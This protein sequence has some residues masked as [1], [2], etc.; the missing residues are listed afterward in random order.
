MGSTLSRS[1]HL[2]DHV[3]NNAH[4]LHSMLRVV[5]VAIQTVC[6]CT[7]EQPHT[8]TVYI[9]HNSWN[10]YGIH[11]LK[12]QARSEI[13]LKMKCFSF[14]KRKHSIQKTNFFRMARRFSLNFEWKV[15]ALPFL[16]VI[17][18]FISDLGNTYWHAC[19]RINLSWIDAHKDCTRRN[20]FLTN[21][22]RIKRV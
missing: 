4:T 17:P 22:K 7:E 20:L 12:L 5:I 3:F 18:I 15:R 10:L 21:E 13:T 6:V 2:P 9:L 11:T 1:L 14:E 16:A 8:H 19:T